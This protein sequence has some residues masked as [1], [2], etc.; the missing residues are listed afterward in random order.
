MQ[1]VIAY[2]RVSTEKQGRSG[3]GLDAQRER[4]AGFAAQNSL[5]LIETF[6]EVETGQGSDALDRR[7]Q[8]AAAL[9]SAKRQRC[10]VLVAKLDRLSRDVHFIAGLMVQR[11]PFLVAELGTD[12]DP[13]MLHIYA[14]LAEKERRMI[15]ERTRAALAAR[16]RQGALL[17]N[18]TNLAEAGKLG[19][20]RT[21]EEARRFAANVAPIIH[22]VRSSGVVS[23]RAVALA[24]NA[25]GVRTARG[26]RWAATQVGAVLARVKPEPNLAVVANT[27]EGIGD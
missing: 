9:A 12:V 27:F 1:P 26:G 20:M 24:L 5:Q 21:Q 17:G 8:L 6:T 14:A 19:A 7:P 23:L 2:Y 16:K 10:A 4:C 18:R 22:Q 25:R 11:V 13:F 3:L 15:S